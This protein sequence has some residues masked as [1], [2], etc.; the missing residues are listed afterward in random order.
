MYIRI[1]HKN[2]KLRKP[3][4]PDHILDDAFVKTLCGRIATWNIEHWDNLGIYEDAPKDNDLCGLC[5]RLYV[6][7]ST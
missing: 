2:H 4:I 6:N 5:L 3:N 1:R 7:G